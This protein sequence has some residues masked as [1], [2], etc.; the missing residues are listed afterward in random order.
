MLRLRQTRSPII[1]N[2]DARPSILE[3]FVASAGW[4]IGADNPS[5]KFVA[6]GRLARIELRPPTQ[7][8]SPELSMGPGRRLQLFRRA[9]PV[10]R[11]RGTTGSIHISASSY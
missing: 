4:P 1:E 7:L 10:A 9:G 3:A 11:I 5:A 2:T 8:R 6:L